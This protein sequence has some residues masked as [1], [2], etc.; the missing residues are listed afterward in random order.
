MSHNV[1]MYDEL[2]VFKGG[3]WWGMHTCFALLLRIDVVEDDECELKM[4]F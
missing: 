1:Q 2:S 3:G 4:P